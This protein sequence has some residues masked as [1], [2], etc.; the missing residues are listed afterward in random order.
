MTE[1][2]TVNIPK[3]FKEEIAEHIK[4]S[5]YSGEKEFMIHAARRLMEE[6]NTEETVRKVLRE[7]N[8]ID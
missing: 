8:L 1:W 2:R 7:E 5:S 3:K 6:E 4:D